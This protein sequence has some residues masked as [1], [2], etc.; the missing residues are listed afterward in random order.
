MNLYEL[1][2]QGEIGREALAFS[3]D[4]QKGDASANSGRPL[5]QALLRKVAKHVWEK[6]DWLIAADGPLL[7][8][9]PLS[10]LSN[11]SNP[12]SREPLINAHT[13]RFLPSELL[14]LTRSTT[15]PGNRFLGVADPIYNLADSR[16]LQ[17][18]S[19]KRAKLAETPVILARL[20]ASEREIHSAAKLSGMPDS[21]LLVGS[22]ASVDGLRR[23]LLNKP[24]IVHFAVH[25]VSP[26]G[27]PE[28][29]ALALSL[30]RDNI[31]ELL[32][33]EAIA[34]L[35]VPGSLI[36]LSGCSSQQGQTLPTAGLVGLSRAWLL[37]GASAVIVSAWPTPDDSGRFFASFYKHFQA[38]ESMSG[39]LARRAACALQQ[40]QLD[41]QGSSG[42]RRSPSFWAAYSIISKE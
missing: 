6:S 35:R 11:A 21:E 37:A 24:E 16:R 25:V 33:P 27:R 39:S 19:S 36:V 13:L 1:P 7:D 12:D 20:V 17:N 42:Y 38:I 30:T 10:A 4:V 34:A 26:V 22:D 14:L 41:M 40:A 3:Q 23:A 18:P 29:A 31:P 32:T 2:S 9:V 15:A 8:G 28:E 5:S